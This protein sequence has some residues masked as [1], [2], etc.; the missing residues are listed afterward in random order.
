[1]KKV[2]VNSTPP[3]RKLVAV[4]G[5]SGVGIWV[6]DEQGGLRYINGCAKVMKP[7]HGQV[8]TLEGAMNDKTR[9]PVY[10]GDTVTIQF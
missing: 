3:P 6:K 10:E 9:T 7:F 8:E 2:T 1:M 4:I 5:Q